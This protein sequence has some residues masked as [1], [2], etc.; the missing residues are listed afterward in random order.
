MALASA[1]QQAAAAQRSS[2]AAQRTSAEAR[3]ALTTTLE[4]LKL[5]D[6]DISAKAR[7]ATEG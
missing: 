7:A 2:V 1:E 3:A 5:A 4:R 6:A